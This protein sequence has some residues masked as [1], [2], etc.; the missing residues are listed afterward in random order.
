MNY[1][2]VSIKK[3]YGGSR[4]FIPTSNWRTV[5]GG[6]DLY[7]PSRW[8][9]KLYK[10]LLWLFLY[11]SIKLRLVKVVNNPEKYIYGIDAFLKNANFINASSAILKS[12]SDPKGKCTVKL[13]D[14]NGKALAY[15]RY[16]LK[17]ETVQ[18]IKHEASILLK[19]NVLGLKNFVPELIYKGNVEGSDGY[20]L[21]QSAGLDF[22]SENY[23]TE[24]HFDFLGRLVTEESI[25]SLN[26]IN[27]IK[28]DLA[29]SLGAIAGKTILKAIDILKINKPGLIKKTLLHGDFAPWNIRKKYDGELFVFDWEFADESG[30]PWLDAL[31]FEFQLSILV[32]NNSIEKTIN[33]M[34]GMFNS[35]H[36]GSYRAK[37]GDKGESKEFYI[38]LYLLRVIILKL[39]NGGLELIEKG[40]DVHLKVL[41]E[42]VQT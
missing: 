31:H 12:D 7:Y 22:K 3:G 6:L 34:I 15:G 28:I 13:M 23:L 20:M 35:A 14:I 19:L 36:A 17:K 21:I 32:D 18:N 4:L 25:S 39:K 24:N 11:A 38:C 40:E 42:Y 16:S 30:V 5:K 33:R 37:V 2:W 26:V 8:K 41:S 10:S 9:G 1:N 27:K 29:E